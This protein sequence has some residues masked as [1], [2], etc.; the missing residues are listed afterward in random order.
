MFEYVFSHQRELYKYLADRYMIL[1]VKVE[2][3]KLGKLEV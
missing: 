1:S 2:L 3:E